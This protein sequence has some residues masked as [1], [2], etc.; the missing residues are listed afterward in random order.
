MIGQAERVGIADAVLITG[1]SRRTLQ[2]L[3]PSIPGASKPAGR[4]LFAVAE[5]RAWVTRTTRS[6]CRKISTSAPASFGRVSRST[7]RNTAKAYER[8][9]SGSR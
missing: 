7:G 9:L 6:S 4:W 2:S 8:V 5:L 1:M 3:A